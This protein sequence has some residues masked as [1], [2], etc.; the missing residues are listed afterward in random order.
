LGDN[1]DYEVVWD[2]AAVQAKVLA[3]GLTAA[4]LSA[5]GPVADQRSLLA[6][7]L[8][9][10]AAG[11][12]GEYPIAD[13]ALVDEFCAGLAWAETLGGT[14]PRAAWALAQAGC[15]G[16]LHLTTLN[17]AVRRLLP[18]GFDYLSSATAERL[19]PHLIVQYPAG[20]R[21]G[22]ADATAVT[23]PAANRLIFVRDD[24]N[25]T[26]AIPPDL[27]RLVAAARYVVVSG[28]NAVTDPALLAD[29]LATLARL[30]DQAAPGAVILWEDAAYHSADLVAPVTAVLGPRASVFSCNQQ[31]LAA[32]A[33]RAAVPAAPA[34]LVA[35]VA[36]VRAAVGCRHL[37]VHSDQWALAAGPD[38]AWLRAGLDQGVL[39][40]TTR[41]RVGDDLS[42]AA[43]AA[44]AR[45]PRAA[46][47]LELA[48]WLDA[49]GPDR[50]GPVTAVP[51]YAADVP[52]PT[53]IGLGDTFLGGLVAGLY[54]TG[55]TP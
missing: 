55:T 52:T 54:Q 38:A 32:R 4:D 30:L 50:R 45:L 33:G 27:A 41:Y 36:E 24:D 22:L 6:T 40:A 26:L 11:R 48:A 10:L 5:P 31:E 21:L 18:P 29:R 43:L 2:Q 37:V 49:A 12:G 23:A 1:I 28:L 17:D 14:G 47:G 19:F 3:A 20:A 46:A 53:T 39:M 35:L 42:P 13:T 25:A 8:A 7:T 9:C 16:T 34:D 15:A 44:T 51:G